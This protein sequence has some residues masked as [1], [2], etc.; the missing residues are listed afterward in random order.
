MRIWVTGAGGY[1]GFHAAIALRAA[2]HTVSGLVRSN[3]ARARQLAAHEVRVV[4]G[5]L[6]DTAAYREHLEQ[7]EVVVHAAW[8]VED[9]VAADRSF[10]D[11]CLR[12]GKQKPRTR[13][14]VYTSC[15]TVFGRRPERWMDELTFT[16]PDAPTAF[17]AEL[18]QQFLALPGWRTA[19]VRPGFLFG[20]DAQSSLTARWFEMGVAGKPVFRGDADKGWS[21]LHV[22]DLADAYLRL[23]E[24]PPAW[25]HEVFC[26]ADGHRP[27][28]LEVMSACVRAAGHSGEVERA[29]ASPKDWTSVTVDHDA[30]MSSEKAQ[31][32]LGWRARQ[33][34]VLD[35]VDT[36]F[37]AWKAARGRD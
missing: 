4:R 11:A 32:F 21:W 3:A 37:F 22:R 27:R 1:A 23:A 9:P 25:Q 31:R 24:A 5:D 35:Q 20:E 19:V 13:L 18:E 7:A 16:Q 33:P 17:R 12:V 28:A 34:G 26:L 6:R 15:S 8:D 30:F 36:Y 2:G 29:R 14:L 10:L